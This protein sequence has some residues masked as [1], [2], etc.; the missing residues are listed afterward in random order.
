MNL[1]IYETT[2]EVI[3]TPKLI[4]ELQHL[5][6]SG[7]IYQS[8]FA[9]SLDDSVKITYSQN[10]SQAQIDEIAN[11]L[12]NFVEISVVDQLTDEQ[13]LKSL[14]GF[15]LYKRLIGDINSQGG[16]SGG[17]DTQMAT[18]KGM[19]VIRHYLKDGFF[20]FAL[21]EFNVNLAAGFTPEKVDE[22]NGWIEELALKYSAT[23]GTTQAMLDGIKAAPAGALT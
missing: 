13:T 21:R 5:P 18:A 9:N 11:H 12:N 4:R 15:N 23:T 7:P 3:N 17:L 22:Y 2:K 10:L 1:N 19:H 16:I 8:F 6:L 20:E 14:D